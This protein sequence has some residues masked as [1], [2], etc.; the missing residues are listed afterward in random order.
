VSVAIIDQN[1]C[2]DNFEF[3]KQIIEYYYVGCNQASSSS[4]PVGAVV[5]E[6]LDVRM[7]FATHQEQSLPENERTAD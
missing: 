5:S 1:I 7:I 2:L 4:S 3:S 6:L